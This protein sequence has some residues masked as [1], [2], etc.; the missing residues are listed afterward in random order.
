MT[1]DESETS[2]IQS[3]PEGSQEELWL[4]YLNYDQ[5]IQQA[6]RRL[7]ALSA[8]NVDLFRGLLLKGRDRSRVKEYEAES[9][10]R[11]QGEAFVGDEDLQRTLI[12]LNAEDPRFG[13]DLKRLVAA[14]GKPAELDKAVAQ[15]RSGNGPGRL[16]PAPD[17]SLR[18]ANDQPREAVIVPL[19]K[20]QV[21]A[22]AP[23]PAAREES[24]QSPEAKR[25][26]KPL[27]VIGAVVLVAAVGLILVM[28]VMTGRKAANGPVAPAPSAAKPDDIASAA[29]AAQHA[30]A[31]DVAT[32]VQAD[33]SA[34]SSPPL[35]PASVQPDAQGNEPPAALRP[36][37][38]STPVPGSKY[39]VARGDM[40]SDIAF[41]V[42]GDASKFRLIQAANPSIRN[43]DRILVDQVIV[44]P[45]D[46][47]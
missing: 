23:R 28:P 15:I 30:P 16:S 31:V 25:N 43:K 7:G 42:Y 11:L 21:A 6:V 10:R 2:A 34:S 44:I 5:S 14:T 19:R 47:R 13:E 40:L 1:S 24:R 4:T 17:L 3:G 35:R 9:I 45:P 41:Q 20:E 29:P 8:E 33:K 38:P 37:V 46:K 32:P 36:S 12:V 26:F 18:P 39:K 27:A 22:P